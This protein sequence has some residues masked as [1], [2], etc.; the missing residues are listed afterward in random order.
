MDSTSLTSQSGNHH[1]KRRDFISTSIKVAGATALL[2]TPVLNLAAK[3]TE[4]TKTYTVQDVIDIILKEVPGAPFAHTVDTIKSGSV[5]QRVTGIVT[6]MFSTIKVIREAAKLTANFIIAHEPT[7]YNHT[8]D[9]NWVAQNEIV[10]KNQELLRHHNIAVWRFHDYWH[11][12]RPDGI[13]YGVLKMAGWQQYYHPE[14]RILKMPPSSL[15]SIIDHLKSS[16]NIA[17]VKVIGDMN[18]VCERLAILPG[19]SGGQAQISFAEREKPDVLIV[20]E[21]HEWET[22]E[23]VRDA[24]LL[25]SKMSLIILGHSVSEE[26]GMQ[27]LVEWLQ[28]KISEIKITHIASEDPFTWV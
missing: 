26:P 4:V 21:V 9:I 3:Y 18:Q 10:K 23:Y 6:T 15:K 11:T 12:V 14:E 24:R 7:F 28:P 13:S 19:A 20:G 8:D 27:W 17:H 1:C 16:L 25:G 2:S 22:A 5:N